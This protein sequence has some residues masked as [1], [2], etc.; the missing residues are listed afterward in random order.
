MVIRHYSIQAGRE[1][2]DIEPRLQSGTSGALGPDHAIW[3]AIDPTRHPTRIRPYTLV[4]KNPFPSG[5]G[6]LRGYG[7]RSPGRVLV[8]RAPNRRQQQQPGRQLAK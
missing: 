5:Q 2:K 1:G 4:G 8:S 3:A 6:P 7:P